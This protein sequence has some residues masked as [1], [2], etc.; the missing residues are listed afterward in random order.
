VLECVVN[1][2]EGRDG[3]V[4]DALRV[5]AGASLLDVHTDPRHNR[6]VLTL[7]GEAV[8][9]SARAVTAQAVGRIDLRHHTGAHPRL[10]AVDVV[11]F[12][13]LDGS[14]FDHALHAR[15]R[16]ATWAATTLGVPCFVYGPERALPDVRRHAFAGLAPDT[17]P[18]A[19]HPSAGAICV[20]ARQVLVAYNLWLAAGTPVAVARRVA[21]SL[22]SPAVRALGLDVGGRAQVSFNLV[23]PATVGPDRVYDAVAA[24]AP[25]ERAELVGLAPSTVL[26]S[27]PAERW[28]TLDLDP[29][30]TI[31]R[32]LA[33]VGVRPTPRSRDGERGRA[34]GGGGAARAR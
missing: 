5:A 7:A 34:G 19:P 23:D 9:Q 8:E 24:V 28:K 18:P 33:T 14:T 17:G 21:A 26:D 32:R 30:R 12:V 4:L 16:F 15:D 11:P 25:V 1:V 29:E 6:T 27:I 31:E 2:S 22:R 20:G 13:P 3:H 10:G